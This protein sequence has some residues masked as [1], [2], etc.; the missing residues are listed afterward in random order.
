[1]LDLSARV[2]LTGFHIVALV[3]LAITV[4][5][6]I[7]TLLSALVLASRKLWRFFLPTNSKGCF[8]D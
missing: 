8:H 6:A 4:H 7:T 5:E 3:V 1:M 2:E